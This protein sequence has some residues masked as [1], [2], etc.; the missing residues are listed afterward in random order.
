MGLITTVL[1][2]RRREKLAA[3]T[4]RA[5]ARGA[6]KIAKKKFAQARALANM[7]SVGEFYVEIYR[8]LT[9]YF[10]DKLNISPHGLTTDTI[11]QELAQRSTPEELI[12][13]FTGVITR[14]DYARFAS[15]TLTQTDI[16]ET[17]RDSE[18]VIIRIE[19]VKFV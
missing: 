8:A 14:C 19:G 18:E 10:A 3:D 15:A 13:S 4:G 2:R 1:V 16:D 9:S 7:D 17:L 11:R 12:E 5:R 6:A